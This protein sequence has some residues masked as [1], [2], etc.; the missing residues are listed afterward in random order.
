[1][2]SIP[3]WLL[4]IPILGFL[5]LIHELGHFITAKK[6]GI[7]V[8]EF[9][10][11]FPPKMY[12]IKK[13]ETEYSINLIPLG[14]FVKMLG[15]EDPTDPRS[16]ARQSGIKR[17]IVLVAG[18]FVN[19]ILPVIIFSILLILP[20]DTIN[21]DVAISSIA[22][23]SPAARAGLESGDIITSVN[24]T[25]IRSTQD[26]ISEISKNLGQKTQFTIKKTNQIAGFTSSAE[27]SNLQSIELTPRKSPPKLKVVEKINDP[28]AEVL[29]SDAQKYINAIQVGDIM[30]QG[31]IGVLISTQNTKTIKTSLKIWEAIPKA[32]S[33]V[34][35]IFSLTF[36]G[37]QTMISRGENP[38]FTGPIGIAQVTGEVAKIGV[39]PIFELI[40][41]LSISLGILNL[42]PIPAL[43]GGRL[44]FVIIEKV[45]GGKKVSPEKEG[46]IHLIGFVVLISLVLLMSYFD[47]VRII[48]GSSIL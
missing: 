44:L 18:S 25:Q 21:G 45:R 26:L 40:A 15:E 34:L 36:S 31:A 14:G 4:V 11:G 30:S 6:F 39:R 22:P 37:I 20:H 48:S 7:K 47:I 29:I 42:L 16:F 8:T 17:S 33:Q 46:L 12:S 19:L 23:G 41:L 32:F 28:T 38:G 24:E 43:D 3:T 2:F 27:F 35:E 13:G 10:F 9:G 1:M 5:V